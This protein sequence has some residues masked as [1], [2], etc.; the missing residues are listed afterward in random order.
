MVSTHVIAQSQMLIVIIIIIT[1]MMMKNLYKNNLKITINPILGQ[2]RQYR[3]I[4]KKKENSKI[5]YEC[6]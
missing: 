3:H 4:N 2:L 6:D 1:S 5:S